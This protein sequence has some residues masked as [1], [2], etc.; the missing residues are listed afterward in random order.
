LLHQKLI[1]FLNK[2]M[3]KKEKPHHLLTMIY[4]HFYSTPLI[5]ND[6]SSFL[7]NLSKSWC[8]EYFLVN[9]CFVKKFQL[10]GNLVH[11]ITTS[12]NASFN[13]KWVPITCALKLIFCAPKNN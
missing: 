3:H 12:T 9:S 5:N 13:S 1:E 4:H 2:K 8:I 11:V 7:F 6:L 10:F